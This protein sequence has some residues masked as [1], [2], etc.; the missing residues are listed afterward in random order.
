M[1]TYDSKYCVVIVTKDEECFEIQGYDIVKHNLTFKHP[2]EGEFLKMNL[3]E[4]TIKGDK[5][6]IAYQDNGK[7]F[8][9]FINNKGDIIDNLEISDLIDDIDEESKPLSGFYE[10]LISAVFIPNDDP[11]KADEPETKAFVSVY[12]RMTKIQYHFTYNFINKELASEIKQVEIKN[13]TTR[14][15]PVKSFY[16]EKLKDCYTFYR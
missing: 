7:F 6:C 1:I 12:H 4:Q 16:S 13:C 9:C 14:N 5:F 8:V 15:F 10:P 11:D 2:I 3:I